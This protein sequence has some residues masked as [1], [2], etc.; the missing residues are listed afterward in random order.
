MELNQN[1]TRKMKKKVANANPLPIL[2]MF[3]VLRIGDILFVCECAPKE[4]CGGAL[5]IV[6]E[7]LVI[8]CKCMHRLEICV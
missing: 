8:P 7:G 1:E 5:F 4:E 6:F 3:M 2:D